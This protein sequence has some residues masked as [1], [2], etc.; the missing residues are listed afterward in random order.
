LYAQTLKR[1]VQ[2]KDSPVG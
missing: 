2:A 1:L